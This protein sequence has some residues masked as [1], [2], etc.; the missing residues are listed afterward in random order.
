MFRLQFSMFSLFVSLASVH[1]PRIG[2]STKGFNWYGTERLIRKHLASRGIPTFMYPSLFPC[3]GRARTEQSCCSFHLMWMA[4]IITAELSRKQFLIRHLQHQLLLPIKHLYRPQRDQ[5]MR[6]KPRAPVRPL[7]HAASALRSCHASWR[8]SEC[9][10]TTFPH[11]N[12]RGWPATLSHILFLTSGC[13]I[14]QFFCKCVR[15]VME[16]RM[17]KPL[18]EVYVWRRRGGRHE[19]RGHTHCCRGG[20]SHPNTGQLK[21]TAEVFTPLKV[22]H[23]LSHN[24]LQFQSILLW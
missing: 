21:F 11:Q 10:S 8:E 23:I 19:W 16:N 4:D 22:F 13:K 1:L 14:R 2:H 17:R 15:F 6:Q 7:C 20:E 18:A 5:R 3:Q 12:G 24:S 9:F